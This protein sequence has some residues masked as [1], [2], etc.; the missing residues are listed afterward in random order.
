MASKELAALGEKIDGD[1][2]AFEPAIRPADRGSF[3]TPGTKG[4]FLSHL[5]VL[6]QAQRDGVSSLLILE[7]DVAFSANEVAGMLAAVTALNRMPWGI[8]YGGSLVGQSSTPLSEIAPKDSVMLAHFIAFTQPVI[9]DLV[10]YLDAM[11]RRPAGSIEGGPMHVDG[12]YSWFRGSHPDI[13]AFAATPPIAHQRSSPTDI[14]ER[15]GLDR[16]PLLRYSLVP[17]R[18]LKNWLRSRT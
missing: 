14:H 17:A 5:A 4:C 2:V 16:L 1:R 6:K 8:F 18:F 11:L 3:E 10:T 13:R 7:D 15:R 12:A 9:E